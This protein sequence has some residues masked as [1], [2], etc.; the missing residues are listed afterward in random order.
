MSMS[1]DN[2]GTRGTVPEE[3]DFEHGDERV[4]RIGD[5]KPEREIKEEFPGRRVREAG[6]TGGETPDG[7]ST[8]DDL[9]PETLLDSEPSRTPHATEARRPADQSMRVQDAARIGAGGGLDE[10]EMAQREPVGEQTAK[11]AQERSRR[12]AADPN[13]VEPHAAAERRAA[14]EQAGRNSAKKAARG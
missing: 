10:A 4:G 5:P 6:M 13:S 8:A 1:K 11:A 12:H 9:T 3:L 7:E 2:T 14:A